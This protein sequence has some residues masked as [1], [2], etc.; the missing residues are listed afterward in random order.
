[1][2]AARLGGSPKWESS[3]W[4]SG[5]PWGPSGVG[6]LK[7]GFPGLLGNRN[8]ARPSPAW[9]CGDRVFGGEPRNAPFSR[10]ASAESTAGNKFGTTRTDHSSLPLPSLWSQM[11]NV[12]GGV[13]ASLPAQKGHSC[14]VS[15][16]CS[17]SSISAGR[18]FLPGAKITQSPLSASR[19][20]RFCSVKALK[21]LT[22]LRPGCCSDNA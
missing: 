15:M 14:C 21:Q 2:V 6:L 17:R 8:S 19:R 10:T 18:S 1:M 16:H 13:C 5:V 9:S 11:E 4:C 7:S 3:S 22:D 20:Q 12:A